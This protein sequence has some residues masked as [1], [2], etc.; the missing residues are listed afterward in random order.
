M[1]LKLLKKQAQQALHSIENG[2]EYP[3]QWVMNRFDT[4]WDKNQK[5]QVIGNMRSVL[6]KVASKKDYFSQKEITNLYDKFSNIAGGDSQFRNE[7]GDLLLEGY[8]KTAG[9]KK[10]ELSKTASDLKSA[11]SINEKSKLSDAFGVLFSF[12]SNDDSGLVNKNLLKKAERLTSLE[13]NAIGIKPDMVSAVKSNEHFIL[14]NAYF[15]N[16]DF[17]SSHVSIPVQISEGSVS[18]PNQVI[19][20]ADLVKLNKEN[21]LVLLKSAQ[22]EKKQ[23]DI[24]KFSQLRQYEVIKTPDVKVPAPLME[25]LNISEELILASNKYSGDQV[26]LASSVVSNEV[27]SWGA[28]AQ[29]KFAGTNDKGLSF[30][31][32]TATSL[33]E[34]SFVVPVQVTGNKVAMPSEFIS[35]ST[36]FDFSKE[37]YSQFL[38]GGK[39]ANASFSRD[40]DDLA[41]LTYAQLMDVVIDGVSKKDY[42]ASED[43]L[44]VVGSKFGPERF[45]TALEDFQKLV[46]VASK[47]L[48]QDLI[49]TAVKNGHLIRTK[50]SVEWF[51]PKLGLPL[52]KIAFDEKGRPVP[53]FRNEKR[54][55]ESIDGTYI[56]NS[57]V[58]IS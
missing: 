27:L 39:V 37:G 31:V 9:A 43:A 5:D 6:S 49:K 34:K 13:L 53:K 35:D 45:K 55:L 54:D 32:K 36:K 16:R 3:S 47:T 30:L 46:K 7:L 4:A 51:C 11:V 19:S 15:K 10:T 52:S 2:K 57:K 48:D 17:S 56:S 58:V 24:S 26:K 29:I 1:S 8:G 12:G 40:F 14:C 20:G 28:R 33:G 18:I 50:N 22:H 38:S 23:K 42:K 21:V 25:K 41:K 44:S